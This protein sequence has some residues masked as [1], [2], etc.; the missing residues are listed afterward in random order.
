MSVNI[1]NV[2]DLIAWPAYTTPLDGATALTVHVDM[3]TKASLNDG[4]M[5]STWLNGFTFGQQFVT[6]T[7]AGDELVIAVFGTGGYRARMTTNSPL[8]INSRINACFR[9]T[10]AGDF[11]AI[12][13]NGVDCPLAVYAGMNSSVT[14]LNS[15][16]SVGLHLGALNLGGDAFLAAYQELALWDVNIGDAEAL[17]ITDAVAPE[18]PP[19]YPTNLFFYVPACTCSAGNPF[20]DPYLKNVIDDVQAHPIVLDDPPAVVT[21]Q[22]VVYPEGSPYASDF[23]VVVDPNP[24]EVEPET[25]DSFGPLVWVEWGGSDD[26][27]RVW[28]PVDLPDPDTYYHG[29]KAPLLLLAG[30][31]VRALS[32]EQ[33]EYQGQVFDATID[34]TGRDIRT[35]LGAS[36]NTRH[37]L[38]TRGVM[39]MISQAD[40]R[41]KLTP[42]TVA[43]GLVRNY[44]LH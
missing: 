31:V 15:V 27:I 24:V 6:G 21:H 38:N 22:Y 12:T 36:D 19:T 23:C 25:G 14:A 17:A 30:R 33:G 32:D 26:V 7:T 37:L 4:A 1:N 16:V 43:I 11:M 13:V 8:V 44:R 5:L 9:W 28:A 2:T 20:N 18:A 3:F 41:L 34:D 39:R 42:R 40:W 29:Y 35:L 10:A